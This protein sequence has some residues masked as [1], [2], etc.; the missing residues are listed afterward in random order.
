VRVY[1]THGASTN[2][3]SAVEL[4]DPMSFMMFMKCPAPT[5]TLLESAGYPWMTT[6]IQ[7]EMTSSEGVTCFPAQDHV[8]VEGRF[9]LLILGG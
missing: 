9:A 4:I 5:P 1:C 2:V 7:G 8:Q 3:A 6:S